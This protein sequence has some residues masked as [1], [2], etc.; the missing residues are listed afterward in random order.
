MSKKRESHKQTLRQLLG[1]YGAQDGSVFHITNAAREQLI[2]EIL[3]INDRF[4]RNP[5]L[6]EAAQ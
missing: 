2:E 3:R 1:R 4:T 6:D 5:S